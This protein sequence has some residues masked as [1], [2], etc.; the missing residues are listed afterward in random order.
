MNLINYLN[1]E[2]I[3]SGKLTKLAEWNV[4]EAVRAV[5][6]NERNQIALMH[7]GAY[8]VYKLPGGGMEPGEDLEV[9]FV[10]ELLEET[11]CEAEKISDLGI[12]VEKRDE[13]KMFQI[14]HCYLAKATKVGNLKLDEFEVKE[15]FTLQWVD[16]IEQAI[17]L[18]KSNKSE[19]YD[20]KY[21]TGR[22][23]AILESA[24]KI[25]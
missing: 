18:V 11:G 5:L 17:E 4:R 16:G 8:G 24:K 1:D 3:K 25:I 14:S 23:L 20:D 7:I 21:I 13:W 6:L 9:A 15:S 19:R 10:R 22:D 12:F 2:D